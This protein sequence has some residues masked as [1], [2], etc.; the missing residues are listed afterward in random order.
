MLTTDEVRVLLQQAKGGN[1]PDAAL[2]LIIYFKDALSDGGEFERNL[3][4]DWILHAFDL[5]EQGKLTGRKITAD[6]AF[7]LMPQ[8]GKYA[9]PDNTVRDVRIAAYIEYLTRYKC[10]KW[11]DA[12][13]EAANFFCSAD[14]GDR[15]VKDAHAKYKS[16]LGAVE[17]QFLIDILPEELVRS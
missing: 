11:E 2:K 16:D 10:V 3:L 13:G 6:Q 12:I 9:R 4:D 17:K 8:K 7:G 1:E 5:I 15:L 14:S